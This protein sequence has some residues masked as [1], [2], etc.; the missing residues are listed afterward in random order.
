MLACVVVVTSQA[1]ASFTAH[2]FLPGTSC[3]RCFI[4]NTFCSNNVA[5]AVASFPPVARPTRVLQ[6]ARDR[7]EFDEEEGYEYERARRRRGRQRRTIVKDDEDT[8]DD[9][10]PQKK[11]DGVYDY[12]EEDEE[13]FEY[14]FDEDFDVDEFLQSESGKRVERRPMAL[15]MADPGRAV[16][17]WPELLKDK[18][19]LRDIA[20]VFGLVAFMDW[21]NSIPVPID[22]MDIIF[23][24]YIVCSLSSL[25]SGPHWPTF[26]DFFST[27][28][29]LISPSC[30]MKQANT[31]N[32]P[33]SVN[34]QGGVAIIG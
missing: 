25:Y 34:R 31:L 32:P 19:A 12:D 1:S 4:S 8:D 7:D 5:V 14:S 3:R 30:N 23:I 20:I 33:Y 2:A 27:R 17:R 21:V 13:D 15:D 22:E 10:Q 24:N 16:D 18:A 6:K 9:E 11:R 29:L 28:I 26:N